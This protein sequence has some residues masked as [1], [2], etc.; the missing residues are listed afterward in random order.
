VRV[1]DEAAST[2]AKVT[3]TFPAWKAGQVQSASYE[4]PVVERS[5]DAGSLEI[6]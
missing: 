4:I 6:D 2:A 5:D 1:P 3:L